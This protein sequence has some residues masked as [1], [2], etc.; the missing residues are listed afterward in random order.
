MKN[1]IHSV[2]NKANV[3]GTERFTDLFG[4]QGRAFIDTP[5]LGVKNNFVLKQYLGL[6]DKLN[7][8]TQETSEEIKTLFNTDKTAQFLNQL[9]GF[10]YYT[11]LILST[12][13]GQVKRFKTAKAL[14]AYAGLVPS[15]YQSGE[16][17]AR[18]GRIIR[19]I[20]ISAG[21]S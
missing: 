15:T 9:P 16:K 2:L 12:E 13:I 3:R 14:C 4:K 17:A 21:F 1:K 7:E 18:H 19:G 5:D 10:G 8:Q 20:N 6:L 11:S